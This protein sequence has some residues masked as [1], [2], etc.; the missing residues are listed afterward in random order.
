MPPPSSVLFLGWDILLM[1]LDRHN[2][3]AAETLVITG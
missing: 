2:M 3:D 1:F